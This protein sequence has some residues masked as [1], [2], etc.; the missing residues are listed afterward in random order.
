[1]YIQCGLDFEIRPNNVEQNRWPCLPLPYHRVY[2]LIS[3]SFGFVHWLCYNITFNWKSKCSVWTFD[4]LVD[5][6]LNKSTACGSNA[7]LSGGGIILLRIFSYKCGITQKT[8][9]V[10]VVHLVMMSKYSKFDVDN[11]NNFWVMG[12]I[13]VFARRRQQRRLTSDHN[14]STFSSKQTSLK[15]LF[16]L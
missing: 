15:W 8:I 4:I 12:Y 3:V 13:K 1:M 2:Q 9:N 14:S 5:F 16:T 6:R 10:R 7:H 11:F